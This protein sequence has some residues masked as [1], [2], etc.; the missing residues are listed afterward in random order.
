MSKIAILTQPIGHNYGGILQAWALQQILKNDGHE[1]ITIDRQFKKETKT[2]FI[3][4][5]TYRFLMK[6]FGKRKAPIFIEK[7]MPLII[8]NTKKFITE[9]LTMS[10][11]LYATTELKNYFDM[12]NYDI[13]IV[14][15]DQTWRPKYSPCIENFYLNFLENKNTKRIAY[16][17]SFGVDNWE[18]SKKETNYCGKL[19]K[20]FDFVGVR[21]DS[22]VNL[23]LENFGVK[24][25]HVLDPTLLLREDDY[26]K[27]IG[28]ERLK[29]NSSGLYSYILDKTPEKKML[30]E[31]IS[32]QMN[33]E[34][35]S[36]QAKN[37]LDQTNSVE[38]CIMPDPRDWLAGFANSNY[39][40]TDSFHGVVFSIIFKKP[41][42][43]ISNEG[44]GSAR[45]KSL[46]NLMKLNHNILNIEDEYDV[47]SIIDNLSVNSSNY[48]DLEY[49][50]SKSRKL[51]LE[52]LY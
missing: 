48:N 40:I 21:E 19:L 9:N 10:V 46:L 5:F 4:K 39:V 11:P 15:S 49:L 1:V 26:K 24:A 29:N 51:L 22:G 32:A 36:C 27:L 8:Q 16:A 12:S 38:D 13:V 30:I 7:M 41:F 31:E 47:T 33:E 2:F 20:L 50:I 6:I 17:S 35:F 25:E 14:G 18:Y 37:N 43:C 28:T 42:I 23:C 3:F 34:V 52:H 44:R 45:F